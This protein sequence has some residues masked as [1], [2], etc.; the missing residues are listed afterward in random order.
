MVCFCLSSEKL[1]DDELK[2]KYGSALGPYANNSQTFAISLCQAPCKEPIMCCT[3]ALCFC[4]MQ[5]YMRRRVLNHVN[6]GSGWS[7]YQ[8]CQGM[9]GGCC[10]LQPGSMGESTCPVPCMCLE[11]LCCAG[12][13]VSASSNVIRGEYSLGLDEDDIRLIRCNNCLFFFS[14]C[15][16]CI[17]MMTE[18]EGDDAAAGIVN[19]I[20]DI[21]FLCTSG[22]MTAQ[23]HHEMKNR[24]HSAPSHELMRR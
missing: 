13:A 11:A 1:S 17:A 4:P 5:V 6:P 18:C 21:V 20:S 24:E 2:G 3:S 12:P 22:C 19:C 23:M 16:S 7:D 9:Y 14:A 8:C 10:C 15:F